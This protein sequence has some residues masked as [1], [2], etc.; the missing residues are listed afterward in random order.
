MLYAGRRKRHRPDAAAALG[1]DSPQARWIPACSRAYCGNSRLR[2]LAQL[3]F[4]F[5]APSSKAERTAD[6]PQVS[7]LPGAARVRSASSVPSGESR[8]RAS[9][10]SAACQGLRASQRANSTTAGHVLLAPWG[11]DPGDACPETVQQA[12]DLCRQ[13]VRCPGRRR[14]TQSAPATTRFRPSS[15]AR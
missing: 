10:R 13:T 5:S 9:S 6:N 3:F 1:A 12:F 8:R 15:L 4:G 2:T 11:V 14:L 7:T